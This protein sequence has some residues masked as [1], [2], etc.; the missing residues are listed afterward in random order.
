[1]ADYLPLNGGEVEAAGG[2]GGRRARLVSLDVFRGLSVALMILVDYAGSHV[3]SIAHSP[4]NGLRLADVVM[5]FFLFIVGLSLALVYKKVSDKISAAYKA[6]LRA[7]KLFLL[8]ILLQGGYFHGINSLTYGVDVERIRWLGILQRISIGYIIAALCEIWFRNLRQGDRRWRLV[9]LN[10][11]HW[12]FALSLS[13]IYLGLLYGLYVPDWKFKGPESIAAA[14]SSSANYTIYTVKC[15]VRGNL[16][17]ACNSAGMIDRSI[18]G[19]EHLHTKPV[20]RNLKECMISGN[21]DVLESIPS[22]CLS[23]FEPEGILSSFSAAVTCIIGLHFGHALINFEDHK[24]RIFSWLT[25][26]ALLISIGLLL[27]LVGIPINKSLYTTSY[28][29]LTSALAGLVFCALYILV[30]VYSYRRVLF[31]LEWMG[32]HS[33]SIFVVVASNLGV[34]AI[35]GFYKASPENNIV[36]WITHLVGT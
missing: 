2:S 24:D 5:P 1:M 11:F 6:T 10:H 27:T 8:G 9:K 12:L 14:S 18:L 13:A 34:I 25:S 21:G 22:W 36:H 32:R 4:W 31:P 35:Q 33:L 15:G 3:P 16:G 19:L 17:P 29:L 23:P 26:S 28:M 7:I 20:Y 30:D